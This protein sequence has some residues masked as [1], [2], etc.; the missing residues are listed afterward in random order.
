MPIVIPGSLPAF[1]TLSEEN[2]FIIN[3][4]RSIHQDIRPL[5]IAIVN[6]MPTKIETET[7]LLRLLGN[8]P[9][10]VNITLLKTNSYVSKNTSEDH[11][12]SFYNVFDDI[13]DKRFDGMIITGAPIETLQFED[14]DYWNELEKIME[15]S[16]TNVTSTFHICWGA[17]AGLYYHYGIN[18]YP[19]KKKMFGIYKHTLNNP[20]NKLFRGFDEVYNAPHSRYTEIKKEDIDKV[21]DLEI[22]S[23][24]EEAGVYVVASKNVKQ[25][26]VTGH[27]EYDKNTLKKE[28]TRDKEKGLEIGVPINYFKND[29]PNLE[30]I[31]TWKSHAHLIFS[32][33]LNYCVYQETPFELK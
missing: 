31:V 18:K 33:W 14:V 8:S 23:E 10:Q 1:E 19:L 30:P 2:I 17:Q 15:F 21:D 11:L 5:E 6:L 24:S 32:N 28:Y 26:F 13:K 27:S 9:L 7:Q 25:I 4:E 20:K 22:L 16:K 3:E 12:S 29:D